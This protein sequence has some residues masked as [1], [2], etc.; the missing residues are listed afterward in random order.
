MTPIRRY[1]Y[2][3]I[4]GLSLLL[5]GLATRY[6]L[7]L[8]VETGLLRWAEQTGLGSPRLKL[9]SV[10][11]SEARLEHAGF[12]LSSALGPAEMEFDDM[13]VDYSLARLELV[14]M[15]IVR[16]HVRLSYRD[17]AAIG[18]AN[19][20]PLIFPFEHGSIEQLVWEVDSPWGRAE[21]SGRAEAL[22]DDHGRTSL[23]MD[24]PEQAIR[25]TLL[26]DRFQASLAGHSGPVL[27]TLE[28][29][30]QADGGF[31]FELDAEDSGRLLENLGSIIPP[32][33]RPSAGASGQIADALRGASLHIQSD[34]SGGNT[35]IDGRLLRDHQ[36]LADISLERPKTGA[37]RAEGN[38]DLPARALFDLASHWLPDGWRP[39][40]GQARGRMH[41]QAAAGDSWSGSGQLVISGLALSNDALRLGD[42]ELAIQSAQINER[43]ALLNATLSHFGK[44][45]AW[46]DIRLP[47]RGA[48]EVDALASVSAA[49]LL[50]MAAPAMPE[51]YRSWRA[52]RGRARGSA[53]LRWRPGDLQ[54]KAE[55][56]LED[57]SLAMKNARLENAWAELKLDDLADRS[58]RVVAEAAS[59]RLSPTLAATRL[60]T[61]ATF[62]PNRVDIAGMSLNLFGGRVELVPTVLLL[63]GG[64]VQTSIRIAGLDLA[65]L[66]QSLNQKGLAGS[67]TVAGELPIVLTI[68]PPSLEIHDGRLEATQGGL[69]KY[70]HSLPAGDNIAFQALRHLLYDKLTAR[71]NYLANGDYGL[72]LRME[73]H[74]PGLL[75]AHPLA[76]NLNLK[77]HL[78]ALLRESLLTG[79]FDHPV[80]EWV[81][82]QKLEQSQTRPN[83]VPPPAARKKR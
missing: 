6:Y 37:M 1:R 15:N 46:A 2:L 67:G 54:G 82:T 38:I 71:L 45:V 50:D 47:R 65:R 57:I 24:G 29:A 30:A 31:R 79:D 76:L 64:P 80:L 81:Q 18:P 70:R 11:W 78:P 23:T 49:E 43:G 36:V 63:D 53:L 68:R 44:A 77:G 3:V 41:W 34:K 13:R 7:P 58:G 19:S 83:P 22:R 55:I 16:A 62:V 17:Q 42:A 39:D 66:L 73:G 14:G 4:T 61:E 69:L 10:G 40:G 33:E 27:L 26:P 51:P 72:N 60:R 56:A 74:N 25:A 35:H 5:A 12:T 59:L 20:G 21:F 52:E 9:K 32:L 8:A 75:N 48:M 28:Y